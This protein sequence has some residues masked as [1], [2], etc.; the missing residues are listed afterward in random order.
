MAYPLWGA[1]GRLLLDDKLAAYLPTSEV[2]GVYIGISVSSQNLVDCISKAVH[3]CR[4]DL[5]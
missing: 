5:L 1:E 2:L 3:T 4:L